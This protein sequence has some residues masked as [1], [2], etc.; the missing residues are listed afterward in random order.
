MSAS[1]LDVFKVQRL[2]LWTAIITLLWITTLQIFSFGK[3][4]SNY[5]V[6]NSKVFRSV[7]TAHFMPGFPT[8]TSVSS[9]SGLAFGCYLCSDFSMDVE[10]PLLNFSNTEV[11]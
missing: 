11:K 3:K 6:K 1:K 8:Y 7:A 9:I 2:N 10:T 4:S 5:E